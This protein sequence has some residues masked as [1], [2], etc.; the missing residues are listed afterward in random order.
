M[1]PIPF[2]TARMAVLGQLG[3]IQTSS[4]RKRLTVHLSVPSRI[5]ILPYLERK[6]KRM[7]PEM[8]LVRPSITGLLGERGHAGRRPPRRRANSL[9]FY[10]AGC[11]SDDWLAAIEKKEGNPDLLQTDR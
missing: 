6:I 10:D 4:T 11:V 2:L 7:A 5:Q 3:K 1:M 9:P 8:L